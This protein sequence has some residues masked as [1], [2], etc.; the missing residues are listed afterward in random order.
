[1]H[2][3]IDRLTIEGAARKTYEAALKDPSTSRI[4][5]RSQ[6]LRTDGSPLVAVALPARLLKAQHYVV[7]TFGGPGAHDFVGSYAFEVV[8]P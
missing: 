5:W 2:D 3:G 4:V 6:P 1:M 8:R 7:D